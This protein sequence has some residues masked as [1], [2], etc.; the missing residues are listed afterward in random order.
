M[1]IE[2]LSKM[3]AELVPEHPE[4]GLPGLGTFVSEFVPASFTDRGYTITPPYKR[5]TFV[6]G[7]ASDNSLVEL[8]ASSNG[9]SEDQSRA[10]LTAFLED[11]KKVLLDRKIVVFPGLGRLRATRQNNI[12]FITDE[13]LNI[14]PE[15]FG[16]ESVSLKNHEETPA[17]VHHVVESLAGIMVAPAEEFVEPS[18]E[19]PQPAE[20]PE[21]AEPAPLIPADERLEFADEPAVEAPAEEASLQKWPKMTVTPAAEEGLP[22][23]KARNAGKVR[24]EERKAKRQAA[25]EAKAAAKVERAAAKAAAKNERAAAKAA[26]KADKAAAIVARREAAAAAKAEKAAAKASSRQARTDAR[27]AAKEAS[28]AAKAERAAAKAAAKAE[29]AASKSAAKADKA[30]AKVAA[31]EARTAAKAARRQ[32]RANARVAAKEA[33][34]ARKAARKPV[35]RWIWVTPLVILA[36][37]ALAAGV[38]FILVY[39]APDFLDSLLY[40]PEELRIINW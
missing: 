19:A 40:T 39:A 18:G 35:P 23:K 36:L 16:L 15:G 38:F 33:R 9:I 13:S 22:A 20:A 34:A 14:Y 30:A 29:R 28:V 12:F 8:Y 4:V 37:A 11:I 24:R 32:A 25:K 3:I 17:E 6:P 1:D 7:K 27:V 21:V 26:A 31:K 2:L 10:T 5:V